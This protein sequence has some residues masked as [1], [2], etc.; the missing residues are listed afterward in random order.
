[1]AFNLFTIYKYF[2]HLLINPSIHSFVHSS[3]TQAYGPVFCSEP[4]L[5][6]I[7]LAFATVSKLCS[8]V[9]QSSGVHGFNCQRNFS[10]NRPISGA[11]YVLGQ[12][13][14]K[15]LLSGGEKSSIAAGEV[16][17]DG[18]GPGSLYKGLAAAMQ[19]EH[20]SNWCQN[21][22]CS[23]HLS[24][25]LRRNMRKIEL[26]SLYSETT[27]A[28]LRKQKRDRLLDHISKRCNW[29]FRAL[30]KIHQHDTDTL[31]KK[32]AD[33]KIGII[34]C[35]HGLGED[36][37]KRCKACYVHR[38][39]KPDRTPRA[40]PDAKFISAMSSDELRAT[41][42]CIEKK[43]G[44]T[45]VRGQRFNLTTN[46]CEASHR[47]TQRS[48]PKNKTF[49]RG[50]SGRAHSAVHSMSL[51]HVVSTVTL[52]SKLGSPN[53]KDSKAFKT[54]RHIHKRYNYQRKRRITAEHN[55]SRMK[56]RVRA[57]RNRTVAQDFG[58]AVTVQNPIGQA[59]HNY[60]ID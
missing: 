17:T 3:G 18:V 45:A 12:A 39:G 10:E 41:L 43:L 60:N 16:V 4:G 24:V 54:L 51:G 31:V 27:T 28:V 5:Q 22:D 37:K 13:A 35:I 36:C 32:C 44:E 53:I 57:L 56:G 42:S 2:T 49:K 59:D 58:H 50:F 33:A 48:L 47:T 29:E 15:E 20:K 25:T 8:C 6:N 9:N 23:K 11:E 52:N 7:P 14:G 46:N 34:S 30:H 55:K 1:M 38:P 40:L 19:Q 21:Q 26:S